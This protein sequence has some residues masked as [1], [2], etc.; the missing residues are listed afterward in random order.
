MI[1]DAEKER[2]SLT[3][4]N[5]RLKLKLQKEKRKEERPRA[6]NHLHQRAKTKYTT[7]LC[8]AQKQ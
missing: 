2:L 4:E 6:I 3:E 1:I 5:R 8:A 7:T